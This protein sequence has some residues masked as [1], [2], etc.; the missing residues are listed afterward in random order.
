MLIPRTI[1][2]SYVINTLLNLEVVQFSLYDLATASLPEIFD[3]NMEY[4]DADLLMYVYFMAWDFMA[5]FTSIQKL[6]IFLVN[7]Y[8]SRQMY[9]TFGKSLKG[10]Y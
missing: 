9:Y 5:G 8:F 2:V 6:L 4:T 7:I 1:I 10:R 3:E